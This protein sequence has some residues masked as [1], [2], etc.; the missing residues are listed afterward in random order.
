MNSTGAP[1]T[2]SEPGK[3]RVAGW[4]P[5]VGLALV[6][7]AASQLYP[8]L[9]PDEGRYAE[10]PREMAASGNW[11]TPRLDGFKYLE[12]PPLQYW[13]TA[14][15]YEAFG[16]SELTARAWPLALA[17][18]TLPLTFAWTRRLYGRHAAVAAL[19]VLATSPVFVLVGHINLLDAA[20]T[21][22]LT[23]V[24][25][26]FVLAQMEAIGSRG[27]RNWMLCA[28][29]AAALAVLSKGIV[30][31]VLVGGALIAYS[32][33]QRDWRPWRRLHPALGLP[34]FLL[35][36]GPWFLAVSRANPE[37]ARFFFLHEHFARF[38]TT[39]HKHGEPWWF[40][41]PIVALGLLPW[42]PEMRAAVRRAWRTSATRESFEPL[43]FLLLF[44]GVVVGFFSISHSKLPPYI[45]P[46]LP[47][48]A[49]VLGVHVA[50]R[51][52]PLRRAAWIAA[53][54]T[55]VVAGG[56]VVYALRRY[57][58]LPPQLAGWGTGAV[59]VAMLAAL[60]IRTRHSPLRNAVPLVLGS[61]LA[62]Q[63][64]IVAYASPPMTRSARTLV[65][66]VRPYVRAQTALYN[67]GQYRQS[68][69]VYLA[70]T[71]TLVAYEGELEFGMQQEPG[72]NALTLEEFRRQWRG[73]V[74]AIAFFGPDIW[75][76][77]AGEG[78]PGRVLA[79]DR[80]S[81]VVS[82]Q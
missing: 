74:D 18:F 24:V 22:W 36:A 45:L 76:A 20:F 41:L 59:T 63:C 12:K 77:M 51:P 64:L 6:W 71:L 32:L 28:W 31:P 26:A 72:L 61:L 58:A 37:F 42:L 14:A 65:E 70:R 27:E 8:L 30:V 39:V 7:F 40:F 48:L 5:W 10:I 55:A 78:M 54:A 9:E 35:V 43:R 15:L 66:A 29:L 56:L 17:F 49:V 21:F 23:G 34:L 47:P 25:F 60:N 82:R 79:S 33:V 3:W 68:I 52:G 44:S 53:V 67:V 16:V 50:D 13:A 73:S 38:L 19:S 4:L 2:A 62:W 1:P 75:Q 81:I 69:P 57:D 80:Y 46:L 11:V